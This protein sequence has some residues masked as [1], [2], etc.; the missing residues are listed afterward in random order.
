MRKSTK[1]IA[2]A[3]G[4]CAVIGIGMAAVGEDT[5]TPSPAAASTSSVESVLGA[6]TPVAPAT[7]ELTTETTEE[8]T[9]SM[10][11]S[12]EAAVAKAR[13]YLDYSGFSRAGLIDQLTSEYGEGFPPADAE[14]AVSYL[15]GQGEV[16]WNAEAVEK[17]RSYQEM[18]PMSRSGLIDQLTSEYGEQFTLDQATYAADQLGL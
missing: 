7:V 9:P 14:F 12:Q 13:S 3:A 5:A 17:A 15:E 6:P 18:S 2:V 16:D 8:A 10:T 1:T 4:A 11:P